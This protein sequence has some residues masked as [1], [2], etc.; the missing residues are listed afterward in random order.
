MKRET[1]IWTIVFLC[2]ALGLSARA[3]LTG[4]GSSYVR[5]VPPQATNNTPGGSEAAL[6]YVAVPPRERSQ[7]G[8]VRSWPR[9]VG[10]WVA[11]LLSLSAL[12]FLYGDTVPFKLAQALVVGVSAGYY[13]VTGFWTVIVP[14]LMGQLAPDFTRAHFTPGLPQTRPD[15]M[16]LVPLGLSVLLLWRLM[17]VGGWISRWPLAFFIGIT[18]GLKLLSFFKADFVDQISNTIL[19]VIVL[20]SGDVDVALSLKN[21]AI[22]VSVLATLVYFCFSVEHRGAIGK[23]S[24]VGIGVLMITFGASFA[25]TVMTRITVFSNTLEFL[26]DDWLWLIDPLGNRVGL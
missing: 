14:N 25:L 7:P 21:L 10:V 2:G 15:W 26:F 5:A 20:K 19:P 24:R 13:L 11:A 23:V 9:T 12:T 17:P 18:A 8:V 22:I 3:A 6:K 4:M 1:L 16:Y